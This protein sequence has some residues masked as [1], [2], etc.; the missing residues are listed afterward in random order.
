ARRTTLH[1]AEE[2]TP[3]FMT[4]LHLDILQAATAAQANATMHL[5]AYIIRRRPLV[6]YANL[7]RLTE[8]VVKSLDPTSPLRESVLSSA[9]LMIS[10][11]IGAYPCIAFHNR[12]QRLAIGTHEGAVVLYDLKTATRLFILEGHQKRVDAVS[13]SP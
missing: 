3:L 12:L 7:P 11:L 10:E 13:F 8:A 6:L 4:T 1:I 5:V 9:T 2:N